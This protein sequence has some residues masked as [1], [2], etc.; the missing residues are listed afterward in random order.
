[1]FYKINEFKPC[2]FNANMSTDVFEIL[3]KSKYFKN[4]TYNMLFAKKSRK[5]EQIQTLWGGTYYSSMLP[6]LL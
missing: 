4:K 6:I 3:N 5:V 2:I 1:M